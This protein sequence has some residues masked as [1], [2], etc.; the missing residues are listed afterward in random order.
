MNA[1]FRLQN[2][3]KIFL[4]QLNDTQFYESKMHVKGKN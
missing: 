2:T 1:L 4:T 3:L